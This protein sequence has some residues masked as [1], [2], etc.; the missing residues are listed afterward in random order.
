MKPNRRPSGVDYQAFVEG[1][2]GTA[3]GESS[4]IGGYMPGPSPA[5]GKR[6]IAVGVP[7]RKSQPVSNIRQAVFNALDTSDEALQSLVDTQL[8]IECQPFAITVRSAWETASS[9]GTESRML[10]EHNANAQRGYPTS[11]IDGTVSASTAMQIP[12]TPAISAQVDAVPAH[13]NQ[14]TI[15]DGLALSMTSNEQNTIK[16][17]TEDVFTREMMECAARDPTPQSLNMN[18][19]VEFSKQ[20]STWRGPSTIALTPNV[21]ESKSSKSLNSLTE[22]SNQV[23]RPR[24]RPGRHIDI[25]T[26]FNQTKAQLHS[27]TTSKSKSTPVNTT[28]QGTI[29]P[30]PLEKSVD[31]TMNDQ[32][33]ARSQVRRKRNQPF[34]DTVTEDINMDP[35]IVHGLTQTDP[36]TT[37]TARPTEEV[38]HSSAGGTSS[39]QD[40]VAETHELIDE[41]RDDTDLEIIGSATIHRSRRRR[42]RTTTTRR[43]VLEVR[44]RSVSE[45]LTLH[46][47]NRKKAKT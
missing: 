1:L 25:R 9:N 5:L 45:R 21:L 47:R 10:E 27:A 30:K 20:E 28:V 41:E 3:L 42:I 8:S 40:L 46:D 11:A 12:A 38:D 31:V 36:A 14:P 24:K 29:D 18:R 2:Y 32:T 44:H 15:Y 23:I 4:T 43:T 17:E 19:T 7:A 6:K 16:K 34:F 26:V 35:A 13:L 39:S 33:A 22:Q 37:A